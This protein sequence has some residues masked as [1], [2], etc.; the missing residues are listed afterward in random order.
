MKN[1]KIVLLALAFVSLSAVSFNFV[2]RYN[3]SERSLKINVKPQTYN[4]SGK[5]PILLKEKGLQSRNWK[6]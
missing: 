5:N 1:L 4:N 2:T 3:M 6:L